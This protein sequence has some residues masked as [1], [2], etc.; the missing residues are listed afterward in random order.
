MKLSNHTKALLAVFGAQITWGIAGPLVKVV[1][2]DIPPFGLMFL[3]FLF[4]TLILFFLY[5]W[6]LAKN[7]PK[8]TLLEKRSIFFAGFLGVFAN[9]ALYFW[10]QQQTT[11]ID[12][13]VITSSSAIFVIFLSFFF[14]HERLPLLVYFGAAL[15]FLGTLVIVGD[16]IRQ[17]GQGGLLGNTAMLGATLAGVISYLITKDL[18]KKFPPLL[19]TYYFFLVSLPFALPLFL[20]EYWQ[21]PLWLV[22]LS[23]SNL[24]IIAYLVLGSSIL[25]YS[26]STAGLKALSPSVAATIGYSSTVIAISL[27]IVF[28]HERPTLFFVFGTIL[29]IVGLFFAES[30]HPAHPIHKLR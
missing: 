20:W 13:W 25:A 18:V 17:F 24:T 11:V 27:S 30:R 15:A 5:E 29:V 22:N 19:L 2:I 26:L 16:G 6:R 8:P 7:A 1:L 9:I 23:F 28:L 10:G 4:T 14:R 12:A 3:R 21:N